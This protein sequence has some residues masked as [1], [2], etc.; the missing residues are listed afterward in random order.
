MIIH[1]YLLRKVW[2]EPNKRVLL[3]VFLITL[4]LAFGFTFVDSFTGERRMD[5]GLNNCYN[6]NVHVGEIKCTDALN[7]VV[8]GHKVAC[9]LKVDN[10][11]AIPDDG[12]VKFTFLNG[13]SRVI[14]LSKSDSYSFI[15]P[16]KVGSIYFEFKNNESCLSVGYPRTYPEYAEFKEDKINFMYMI[17]ALLG[18][19][20]I[21][22]PIIIKNFS[23]L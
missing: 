10:N 5:F 2:K 13:E 12:F 9:S 23:E 3:T 14:N 20:L 21:S 11:L 15:V 7:H 6:N 22:V 4:L 16:D 17:L 1:Y 8:V 19:C 18:F